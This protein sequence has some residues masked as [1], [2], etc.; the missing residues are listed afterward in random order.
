MKEKSRNLLKIPNFIQAAARAKVSGYTMA[1]MASSF[2]RDVS[3]ICPELDPSIDPSMVFTRK[4]VR[5]QQAD[6]ICLRTPPILRKRFDV[7]AINGLFR[8]LKCF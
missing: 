1:N 7:T 6:S 2:M 4:K 8:C 3:K 5:T